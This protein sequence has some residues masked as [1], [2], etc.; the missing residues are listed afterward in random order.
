MHA[1][2]VR[3]PAP[4]RAGGRQEELFAEEMAAQRREKRR[5][6]GSFDQSGPQRVCHRDVPART[7]SISPATP[8]AESG[9]SS[10]GSQ[11]LIER[12]RITST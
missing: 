4:P 8:S 11:K 3:V 6:C 2:I 7:A 9:R 5:D 1:Q 12:R 10:S